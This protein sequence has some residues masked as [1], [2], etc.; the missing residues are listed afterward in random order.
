MPKDAEIGA[1]RPS[2]FAMLFFVAV[3]LSLG[4]ACVFIQ[5]HRFNL[6]SLAL[7]TANFF[8]GVTHWRTFQNRLV[9]PALVLPIQKLLCAAGRCEYLTALR[10]YYYAATVAVNLVFLGL[11][12]NVRRSLTFGFICLMGFIGFQVLMWTEW[13][14]PW[15]PLELLLFSVLMFMDLKK[16]RGWTFF[17][18]LFLVWV[19]S[20]ETVVFVPIWLILMRGIIPADWRSPRAWW[21][22]NGKI[23]VNAFAMLIA[24]IAITKVL[25]DRLFVRSVLPYVGTDAVHQKMGDQL[26]LLNNIHLTR[27]DILRFIH[28]HSASYSYGT[29][30]CITIGC[31]LIYSAWRVRQLYVIPP[32]LV[33]R[34]LL[35]VAI[36][37][38]TVVVGG[39]A[40]E[41]RVYLPFGPMALALYLVVKG[42]HETVPA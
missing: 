11:V 24:A 6:D 16:R 18:L 17:Y 28:F 37:F 30:Y 34:M 15:D 39:F 8:S 27:L 5:Y 13:Y 38:L 20:K 4:Q 29:F 26:A 3:V 32:A 14:Y 1:T 19:F 7:A 9:G 42:G 21:G 31:L 23:A 2:D 25:R 22:L 36:Y 12:L 10:G 41:P 40:V 35:F 33:C